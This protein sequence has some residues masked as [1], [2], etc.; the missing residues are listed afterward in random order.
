MVSAGQRLTC[1]ACSPLGAQPAAGECVCS[2]VCA[3]VC[4]Q[5]NFQTEW[6]SLLWRRRGPAVGNSTGTL[7]ESRWRS[8]GPPGIGMLCSFMEG[9]TSSVCEL[10]E[11]GHGLEKKGGGGGLAGLGQLFPVGHPATP[12]FADL[13]KIQSAEGPSEDCSDL[14]GLEGWRGVLSFGSGCGPPNFNIWRKVK[15]LT[16]H[17]QGMWSLGFCQQ[18]LTACWSKVAH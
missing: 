8:W 9:G 10:K 13:L 15:A 6:G 4:I 12:M 7:E 11:E 14:H 2:R 5:H 16:S 3:R 18:R 1:W 17:L